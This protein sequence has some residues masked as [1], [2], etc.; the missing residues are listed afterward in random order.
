MIRHG[1]ANAA[2]VNRSAGLLLN[3]F[4]LPGVAILISARRRVAAVWR[5]AALG[6]AVGILLRALAHMLLM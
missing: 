4:D 6:A 1:T 5:P 3:P 2:M